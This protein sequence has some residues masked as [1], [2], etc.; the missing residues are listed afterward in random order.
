[1]K[2]TVISVAAAVAVGLFP[3]LALAAAGGQGDAH[4]GGAP[5]LD[6]TALGLLWAV[7]FAGMLL[8]IAVFPLVAP[9]F[10]EHNFGKIS[11]VWIASSSE[12]PT[13]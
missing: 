9:H 13:T 3:V 4:A 11:A 2:K 5:H 12:S 6:G 1:M 10:W 8:S 7:P